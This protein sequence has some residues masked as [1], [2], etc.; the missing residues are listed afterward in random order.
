MLVI[1][2]LNTLAD[3][4]QLAPLCRAGLIPV[5][6]YTQREIFNT[7]QALLT[8]PTYADSPRMA[9]EEAARSC[10]VTQ[11]SVYRALVAMK[12]RI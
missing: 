9:I 5:R 12:A 3:S 7:H 8:L 6:A 2:Y 4:K 11:V 1:D 10:K